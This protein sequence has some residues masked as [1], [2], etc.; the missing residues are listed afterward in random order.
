MALPDFDEIKELLARSK[1][2]DQS[3]GNL[4]REITTG[5]L[6]KENANSP[7]VSIFTAKPSL[8]YVGFLLF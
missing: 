5:S 8:I 3:W 6:R 7:A 4:F 2:D 1:R